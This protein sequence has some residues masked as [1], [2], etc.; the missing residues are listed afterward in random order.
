MRNEVVQDVEQVHFVIGT[1]SPGAYDDDREAM[2]LLDAGLGGSMSSRIFQEVREK[3]GLAYSVGSYSLTY[4][5]GGAFGVYGGTGAETWRE[6]ESLVREE[7]RKV[8]EEGLTDLEI[9]RTKLMIRGSLLMSLES[10]NSRMMRLGRQEMVYGRAIPPEEILARYDAVSSEQ[11]MRIAQERLAEDSV[12]VTAI[13][14]EEA[15]TVPV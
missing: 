3:R 1:D 5:A 4:S 7:M 15:F 9:E 12:N 6:V 13:G 2:V 10:T 11:I 14:P 8:R